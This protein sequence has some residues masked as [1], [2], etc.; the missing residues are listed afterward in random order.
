MNIKS[1]KRNLY[2][3]VLIVDISNVKTW[4]FL[5]EMAD[6]YKQDI[7][8]RFGLIMIDRKEKY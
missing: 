5:E 6:L 4:V 2:N 1:I 3:I 7:P 8:V